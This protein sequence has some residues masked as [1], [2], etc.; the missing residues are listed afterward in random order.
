MCSTSPSIEEALQV[1]QLGSGLWQTK[2]NGPELYKP[3]EKPGFYK[4]CGQT[5]EK[6][7]CFPSLWQH[8]TGAP[9]FQQCLLSLQRVTAFRATVCTKAS[10]A[11]WARFIHAAS[12][13]FVA[14]A[15]CSSLASGVPTPP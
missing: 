6:G 2:T 15:S 14:A 9:H 1:G 12:Q 4:P 8:L 13:Q 3:Q 10:Q 5:T 7:F 11:V